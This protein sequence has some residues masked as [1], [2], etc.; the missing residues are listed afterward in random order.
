MDIALVVNKEALN[1]S[2]IQAYLDVFDAQAISYK[3]FEV[4]SAELEKTLIDCIQSFAII[5]V[6]GGDGTVRTAAEKCAQTS[7]ILGILPLGTMNH[8]AKELNLPLTAEELIAALSRKKTIKVDLAEVNGSIFVNNSSIGFYPRLAKKR[9]YYTRFY[10]KWLSYIPSFIETLKKHE[11]FNI[12]VTNAELNFS[13]FTSFFMVSN[14]LYSYQFPTTIS[15]KQFDEA[16]LGLY[17]F[18]HGKLRLSK[19]FRALFIKKNSFEIKTTT[20][21]LTVEIQSKKNI[22]ISLDGDIV[23]KDLPLVYSVL[24]QA[25]NLLTAKS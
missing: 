7:V 22:L 5:L 20:L 23:T 17:F 24:P 16:I 11:S 3:L 9:N 14:N 2:R 1:A 12:T 8:F 15:R 10:N 21:P 13:L 4:P 18:K 25:L 19:I 6:G